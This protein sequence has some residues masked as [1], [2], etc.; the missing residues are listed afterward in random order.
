MTRSMLGTSVRSLLNIF[1]LERAI[2]DFLVYKTSHMT[3][4]FYQYLEDLRSRPG[5]FFQIHAI[6]MLI[7]ISIGFSS[8]A[9]TKVVGY[10]TND[11][12]YSVDY[13]RITH[14]NIA[15]EK[16]D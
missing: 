8:S 12:A 11:Q 14:L 7:L 6:H 13:S 15:F 3:H 4:Y 9:Q 2:A 5:F 10:I 1:R 16:P